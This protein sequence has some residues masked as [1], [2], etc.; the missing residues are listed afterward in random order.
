MKRT[1]KSGTCELCGKSGQTE[2]HHVVFKSRCKALKDSPLNIIELCIS[3][4]RGDVRGVH[5]NKEVD[6]GIKQYLKE[7]ILSL[8]EYATI[9]KIQEHLQIKEKEVNILCKP[10]K[11]IGDKIAIE[12]LIIN[13]GLG[14]I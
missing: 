8:G 12:D 9:E 6:K 13:I 11:R 1:N 5:H 3:C 7:N 4:H 2:W 14:G 10:L